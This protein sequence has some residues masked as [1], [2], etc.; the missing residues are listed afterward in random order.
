MSRVFLKFTTTLE[1]ET[2]FRFWEEETEDF[3]ET[4]PFERGRDFWVVDTAVKLYFPELEGITAKAY[5]INGGERCKSIDRVFELISVIQG[6][7]PLPKRVLVL[8]GGAVIDLVG[9][10]VSTS[11]PNLELVAIPTTPSAQMSGFFSGKFFLDFDR[12]KDVFF[13]FSQPR[14]YW[15]SP[16]FLKKY[17]LDTIR[18]THLFSLGVSWAFE[19]KFTPLVKK[20][21]SLLV[22]NHVD[23]ILV[24]EIIR[25]TLHLRAKYCNQTPAF[26]GEV[27]ARLI[28]TASGLQLDWLPS[29]Y[30]GMHFELFVSRELGMI[31]EVCYNQLCDDLRLIAVPQKTRI[32]LQTLIWGIRNDE[33]YQLCLVKAIGDS[34]LTGILGT[35][36]KFFFKSFFPGFHGRG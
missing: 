32:D 18:Q 31:D 22:N 4:S 10:A 19:P 12:K 33:K 35:E 5:P 25:E 14:E 24:G 13:V 34:Q 23:W 16:R 2:L 17:E 36:L 15:I 8:G 29:L 7:R 26:P 30:E 21:L 11:M 27:A 3:L 9:Y 1:K 28:Q 6:L 20:S